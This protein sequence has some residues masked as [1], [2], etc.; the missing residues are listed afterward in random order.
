[1]NN[2]RSACRRNAQPVPPSKV[3]DLLFGSKEGSPYEIV[4]SEALL[5]RWAGW[6]ARIGFG[7]DG[8]NDEGG[9]KT[10][11]PKNGSNWLEIDVQGSG[12]VPIIGVPPKAKSSLD[13][14]PNARKIEV[15]A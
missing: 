9:K 14:D 7:F 12:W 2:E 8:F 6:P 3:A 13:N 1:M 10:I 5:A 11:R 15:M 4:A